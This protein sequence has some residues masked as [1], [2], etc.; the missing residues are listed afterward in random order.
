MRDQ[1]HAAGRQLPNRDLRVGDRLRLFNG[2][3]APY[4]WL[5]GRADVRG[6]IEE[7][8]PGLSDV[9]MAVVKLDEPLGSSDARGS[10]VVLQLRYVGATWTNVGIVHIELLESRPPALAPPQRRLGL[11]LESHANY[12]LLWTSRDDD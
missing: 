5:G 10:W 1:A 6:A 4:E 2:Y 9:P 11:H 12:E 8:I 7:F 3:E